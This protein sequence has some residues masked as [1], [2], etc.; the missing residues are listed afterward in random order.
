MIS[1][2]T[3]NTERENQPKNTNPQW[4]GAT[5]S[6]SIIQTVLPQGTDPFLDP[7]QRRGP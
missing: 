2:D 6:S 3:P 4:S 5:A 7:T 1:S